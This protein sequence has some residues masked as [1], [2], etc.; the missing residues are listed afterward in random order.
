MIRFAPRAAGQHAA[1]QGNEPKPVTPAVDLPAGG[2]A[3][4]VGQM[5]IPEW[6]EPQGQIAPKTAKPRGARKPKAT[7][8]STPI[9]LDLNAYPVA[10]PSGEEPPA[11]H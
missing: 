3:P 4:T 11:A 10:P 8:K 2:V 5:L 7:P 6:N 1:P 9:Q